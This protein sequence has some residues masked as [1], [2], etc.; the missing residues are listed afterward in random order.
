MPYPPLN[1]VD[2]SLNSCYTVFIK[3]ERASRE[4]RFVFI[5]KT[6]FMGSIKSQPGDCLIMPVQGQTV[7]TSYQLLPALRLPG[8]RR[9]HRALWKPIVAIF[10]AVALWIPPTPTHAEIAINAIVTATNAERSAL[11][12]APVRIDDR[13]NQAATDKAKDMFAQQ[14]FSHISP[15]G[16]RGWAWMQSAG[17]DYTEAGENLAIDFVDPQMIVNAW[18][19][20]SGHRQNMI[21]PKF[22]AVG[23]TVANGVFAGKATTIVVMLFGRQTSVTASATPTPPE[24]VAVAPAPNPRPTPN[25]PVAALAPTPQRIPSI[26]EPAGQPTPYLVLTP[27]DPAPKYLTTPQ[28]VVLGVT[29]SQLTHPAL[30][31]GTKGDLGFMVFAALGVATGIITLASLWWSRIYPQPLQLQTA[32]SG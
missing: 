6:Q 20:S 3:V 9:S 4:V 2:F 5:K 8:E 10:F 18:M 14:Y 11:G 7:I 28:P 15:T 26:I 13:L 1:G 22:T 24:P 16:R 29:D 32:V 27:I 30:L 25:T 19:E 17:Y 21:S 23:V 31:D 12:V